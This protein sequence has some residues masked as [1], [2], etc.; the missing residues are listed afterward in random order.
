MSRKRKTVERRK[1]KK[2]ERMASEDHMNES[3]LSV[4]FGR[5]QKLKL[6]IIPP[7]AG[8]SISFW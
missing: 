5:R 1:Y 8:Y 3:H 4:L 6:R 2:E 7:L